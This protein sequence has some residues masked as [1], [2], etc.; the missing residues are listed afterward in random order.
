MHDS[1]SLLE[2]IFKDTGRESVK[3]VDNNAVPCTL[4]FLNFLRGQVYNSLEH[5]FL[6]SLVHQLFMLF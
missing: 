3:L 6:L 1:R 4:H 5:T 2:D